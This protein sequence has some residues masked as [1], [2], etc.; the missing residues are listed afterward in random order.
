MEVGVLLLTFWTA[1]LF[2]GE[3]VRLVEDGFALAEVEAFR[4]EGFGGILS[5]GE[6]S[7]LNTN[8]RELWRQLCSSLG[9]GRYF[10]R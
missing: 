9:G 1:L 3:V 6:I 4:F 7:V 10:W 8:S 5:E 2:F